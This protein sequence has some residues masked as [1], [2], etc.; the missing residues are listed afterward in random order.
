M[1]AVQLLVEQVAAL[2]HVLL[3]ALALEPFADAFL[4]RGALDEV[5]PVAARPVWALRRK[6]FHELAVLKPV[7]RR[8]HP[9]RHPGADAPVPRPRWGG[10]RETECVLG[11]RAVA[12]RT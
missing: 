6:A 2:A 7:A 12:R 9:A 1:H 10:S 11:R 5:E 4:G 8:R 3:A